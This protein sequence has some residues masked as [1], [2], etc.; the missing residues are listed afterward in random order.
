MGIDTEFRLALEPE[1]VKCHVSKIG[2]KG[3]L[4]VGGK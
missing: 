4:K 3:N 1:E 2:E